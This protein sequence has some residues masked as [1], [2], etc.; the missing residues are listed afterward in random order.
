MSATDGR[1]RRVEGDGGKRGEEGNV[2]VM[3]ERRGAVMG[4]GQR[5]FGGNGI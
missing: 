1:E 4:E 3:G 5:P 2:P